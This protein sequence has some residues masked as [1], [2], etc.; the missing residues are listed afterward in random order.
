MIKK[1]LE[2]GKE[3]LL[4]TLPIILIVLL[5]HFTIAPMTGAVLSLFI[6]G[7]LF[8]VV[9]MSLFN[10]GADM[11]MMPM[12]EII[13]ENLTKTRK[14]PLICAVCFAIGVLVTIAE[15]DLTVLANQVPSIP[16]PVLIW[17]VAI[18]V[19]LFLVVALLR[20]FYQVKLSYMLLGF[21]AVVFLIASFAPAEFIP[22]A[23]D[24]GG[25]T[26]GPIT[27]PFIMALGIGLSAVRGDD[28]SEQDSFGL[29]ALCS[30][31]PI[32][33]VLILGLLYSTEGSYTPVDIPAVAG[34]WNIL[35]IF[36]HELPHY[37][38]EVAIALLPMT[39]FFFVFQAF[40]VKL[41]IRKLKRIIVGV[42]Y[43]YVGLVLFLTGVNVGFMPAGNLLGE[44]VASGSWQW[45]LIPLGMVIGYVIVAAEPAVHVLKEQVSEIT[46]GTISK[47]ALQL[48]LSLGVAVAIGLALTRIIFS[49]S[50]WWIIIPGYAIAMILTFFVPDIFTAIAFDSGGV[51]SGPMTAT[52]LL[53]LAMGVC[54][55]VGG[56]VLTDAFGIVSLVAMSPLITIQILGLIYRIKI[57]RGRVR[58]AVRAA[59][60]II[61]FNREDYNV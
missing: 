35:G 49:F 18:G 42:I 10:L 32:L 23:F 60:E 20:I 2:K 51:A 40:C 17:T 27:V 38:K 43:A 44:S 19:G 12:G 46:G 56:N 25:V 22:V 52:F 47:G 37:A 57:H 4:S 33:S 30:I 11:A 1:L 8:L 45:I 54:E 53:P 36:V 58:D 13:G 50:I 3:S 15:P 26:T 28:A 14:L 24:S 9:G 6:F 31:G 61:E 5:L 55:A 21:Y 59:A 41:H 48:S 39:A 16:N 29:V 34:I 7:A